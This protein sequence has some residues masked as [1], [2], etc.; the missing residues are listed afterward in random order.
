MCKGQKVSLKNDN[1]LVRKK[2]C[3][4]RSHYLGENIV[5]QFSV[6]TQS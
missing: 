5:W 4:I 2:Y 1:N 3:E 6:W